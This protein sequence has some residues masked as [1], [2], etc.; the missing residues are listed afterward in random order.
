MDSKAF[1]KILQDSE[2]MWD[3]KFPSIAKSAG[4]GELGGPRPTAT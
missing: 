2:P 1:E 4:S 3:G